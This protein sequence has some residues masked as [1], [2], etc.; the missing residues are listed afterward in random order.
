MGSISNNINKNIDNVLFVF[1]KRSKYKE[2]YTWVNQ[3]QVM[4][5]SAF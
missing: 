1:R 4:A 5:V 3:P 2:E